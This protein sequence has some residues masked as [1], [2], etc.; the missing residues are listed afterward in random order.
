MA[1]LIPC[2]NIGN[3]VSSYRRTG[4][5]APE[6]WYTMLTTGTPLVA[7]ALVANILT[8]I[9]FMVPKTI[10]LDAIGVRV[11]TLA[12]NKNIELG[13]Y[14]DNGNLYPDGLILDAGNVSTTLTGV[15]TI[16]INQTLFKNKLYWLS[17]VSNATP[18]IV[19]V[20]AA[21]IVPVLGYDNTFP[22]T[23]GTGYS[24]ASAYGAL[25][26]PFPAGAAI[27]VSAVPAV[28]VRL[29]A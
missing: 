7:G 11:T 28:F 23:P 15:K 4:V 2:V 25:P 18:S 22:L 3:D 9:P 26:D 12:L 1:D 10:T 14:A 27:G 21:A 24:V 29:S 8:A 17:L 20:P 13:I 5:V 16:S 6:I 19:V